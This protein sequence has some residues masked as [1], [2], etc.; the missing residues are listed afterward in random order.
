MASQISHIL[1]ADQ[2]LLKYPRP[3]SKEDFIVG[4]LFPDIRRISN[5][6]REQTHQH[7]LELDLN[8]EG[9]SSFEAGWKFHVW[10]DLRRN[11]LLRDYGFFDL[12]VLKGCHYLSYY[13]LEDKLLWGK[14]D[15]WETI[16][17]IIVNHPRVKTYRALNKQ[18]WK[19]WYEIVGKY[20]KKEPS[21]QSIEKFCQQQPS[22]ATKATRIV[23]EME[24]LEKN[25]NVVDK[26]MKVH[27]SLLC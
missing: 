26:L 6:T 17:N 22:L 24:K 25:K 4:V 19:F 11:E 23:D 8:F 21:R 7:F 13:F 16:Y 5:L 3:A 12:D 20:L 9:L 1:Y 27:Q 15:N 2:Y 14:Y 18:D 10:C